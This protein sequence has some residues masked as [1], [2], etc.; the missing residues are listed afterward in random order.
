MIK[1]DDEVESP[2]IL[3]SELNFLL[4]RYTR[5]PN[6]S[7]AG[8]IYSRLQRLLPYL[9]QLGFSEDRCCFYKL[10]RIWQLRSIQTPYRHLK[11]IK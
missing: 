7:L 3:K 5:S 1:Y 9:E 6:I 4:R 2:Q 8:H 10:L 11:T